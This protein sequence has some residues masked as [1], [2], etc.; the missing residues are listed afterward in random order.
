[1]RYIRGNE[2]RT[3]MIRMATVWDRTSEFLADNLA[4]LLPLALLTMF[5]PNSVEQNLASVATTATPGLKAGLSIVTIALAALTLWGK[6][7][8]TAIVVERPQ[9]GNA[10]EPHTTG[11]AT[12]IAGRRLLP[13]IGVLVLFGLIV[14]ALLL[15]PL[16]VLA[17]FRFDFAT[18]GTLPQ[19]T[20]SDAARVPF[21]IALLVVAPIAVW[22]MARVYVLLIPVV[23]A[24]RRGAGA[25]SR[26]FALSRGLV[27]RILG[28]LILYAIVAG[29]AELAAKSVFGTIF[30]LVV[31]GE[32]PLSLAKI[33]TSIV[34]GAVACAFTVLATVFCAKLYLATSGQDDLPLT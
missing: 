21:G 3:Y 6:L 29:I 10:A 18:L 28:V 13:A 12:G 1:M 17:L 7:A 19:A 9:P 32:G 8:I 23:L 26:A 24:E 25:I 15:P 20:I 16:A 27:W 34:S 4:K 33:L 2:G 22:L 30:E 11:A 31:G 14:L 5:L